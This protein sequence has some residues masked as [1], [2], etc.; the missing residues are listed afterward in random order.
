M[1]FTGVT[2]CVRRAMYD[3]EEIYDGGDA[4]EIDEYFKSDISNLK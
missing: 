2:A 4:V 1:C 3:D